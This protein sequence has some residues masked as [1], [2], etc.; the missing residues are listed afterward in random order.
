LNTEKSLLVL[1]KILREKMNVLQKSKSSDLP[2][3]VEQIEEIKTLLD[4]VKKWDF[5]ISLEEAQNL[6]ATYWTNVLGVLRRVGGRMVP[7]S[8]SHQLNHPG[9]K[10]GFNVERFSKIS[11]PNIPKNEESQ[12]YKE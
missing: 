4:L 5:E 3:Q 8:H 6:M 2:G 10:L 11:G 7:P 1:N 9:R 12:E